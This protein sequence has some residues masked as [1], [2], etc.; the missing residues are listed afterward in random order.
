METRSSL[1]AAAPLQLNT[2]SGLTATDVYHCYMT[3]NYTPYHLSPLYRLRM[4]DS[5]MRADGSVG[6]HQN[7]KS[8]SARLSGEFT[9]LTPDTLME[10]LE[11]QD[12]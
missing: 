7:L 3:N 9:A 12:N 8:A 11:Q 4:A 5:N 6:L 1:C 10:G 2:I